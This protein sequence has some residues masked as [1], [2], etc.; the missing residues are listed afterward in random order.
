VQVIALL[1]ATLCAQPSLR[2]GPELKPAKG[3][4]FVTQA[5]ASH[6]IVAI[7]DLPGCDELH[8]FLRSLIQVPGFRSGVATI[9]VDFGNP[10]FQPVIDRYVV[11][12]ERVPETVLRHIWDD[13][14][15]SPELTWDSPL[16]AQFFDVVRAINLTAPNES[17]IRVVLGDAPIVWRNVKTREQWL[18][19]RGQPREQVLAEKISEVVANGSRAL[20]IAAASH[21]LAGQP[22]NARATI[23]ASRPGQILT[24]LT[25]GRLGTGDLFKRIEAR[26]RETPVASI[27]LVQNTWLGGAPLSGDPGSKR[28]QDVA[29]AVLY[30]GDSG[31]LTKTQASARLFQDE[32]FW[33]ELNRRWQLVHRMP[34]D[35]DKAGFDLRSRFD[36]RAPRTP[37][38]LPPPPA[39]LSPVD[40]VDF[41]LKKL[42]EYPMVGIGDQHMCLEFYE[43][44]QR[45]IS[46]PRL[47]DKI[48]DIIVEAGNPRYQA[49]ID[50]YVTNGQPVPLLE[51][52]P[53]WQYAAMGWYEANSP[54]YEKFFDTVRKVN[55]ALP[56]QK[57]F[58]V[59]LGDAPIDIKQLRAN[60][61]NYLSPFI[62]D[63]ETLRDP[64][65][66]SI[67]AAVS[68]VLGAGRRGI[69]IT[70]SGHLKL[71]GRQGN[72]RRI[73]EPKFPGQFYLI[74]QNGPG[75]PGWPN[76]SIVVSENDAEPHHATLWLGPFENRTRVRPSP[77]IYLDSEYWA[78]INLMEELTRQHFPLDLEETM[79]QYRAR[80]F[81]PD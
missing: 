72:S 28:V 57:R 5:F 2:P 46:N 22:G 74:D 35:F 62:A 24:V 26:E 73:F 49:V 6:A 59:I 64:R 19:L 70:G 3:V 21:L 45:L 15:E 43:F 36:P 13:T 80:Y 65:E 34:F 77:L 23:E 48:Q 76:P 51:R 60:P 55:I 31:H 44:M 29:E 79:F 39:G 8:Q 32:E 42:D 12:G 33:A 66:I 16:Y 9:V 63:K 81:Y 17:R 37:A 47:P 38:V 25:Q 30:L 61:E 18:A 52:K 14:T 53:V 11:N 58:R 50:R 41:V 69:I 1:G 7:T 56:K 67:A 27:A 68:Q 71:M 20:V 4:E 40:A 75:Y 78:Y 54:V 10:L